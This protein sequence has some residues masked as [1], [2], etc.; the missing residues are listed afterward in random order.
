MKKSQQELMSDIFKAISTYSDLD[1]RESF[2]MVFSCA[3][4]LAHMYSISEQDFINCVKLA[5]EK[6]ATEV[7]PLNKEIN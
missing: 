6:Q 3:F 7:D 2:S 5:Y 4:A 1:S